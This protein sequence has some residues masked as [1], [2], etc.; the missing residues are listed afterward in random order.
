VNTRTLSPDEIGIAAAQLRD[1]DRTRNGIAPLT[2][3]YANLSVDDAYAIQR[4][5]LARRIAGGEQLV[6]RKIGLTSRAMQQ[7]LGVSEPDYGGITDAMQ[8]INGAEL[9]LAPFIA[10]RLEAEFAFEIGEDLPLSPSYAELQAAVCG[11]A[12]ALEII[13]SRVADWRIKLADTIA[14]NASMARVVWGQFVPAN[15]DLLDALPEMVISLRRDG[16]AL[17]AGAGSAV[18]GH[19]ITSLHWLAEA[20]GA[21][22]DGLRAGDRVLAGAVSAAVELTP[23]ASW[24][25]STDGLDSVTFTTVSSFVLH[26]QK[27]GISS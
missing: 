18:L 26:D 16:E 2:E 14:D 11:V 17:T 6:G 22:G 12:V 9:D 7:Q 3:T 8:I 10:P 5:N 4:V 25:A 20:L 23:G 15:Q 19:P 13:D 21:Q 27:G 24:E 1:A